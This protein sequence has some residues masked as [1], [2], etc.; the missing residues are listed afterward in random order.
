M[1]TF[2]GSSWK[3]GRQAKPVST[4]RSSLPCSTVSMPKPGVPPAGTDQALM[5]CGGIFRPP[6]DGR[7]D[8]RR[9]GTHSGSPEV[10]CRLIQSLTAK[11]REGGMTNRFGLCLWFAVLGTAGLGAQTNG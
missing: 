4:L 10:F 6:P 7:A 8:D 5:R 3:K 2:Y 1:H 11:K 9:C